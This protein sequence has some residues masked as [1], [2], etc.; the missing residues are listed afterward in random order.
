MY[1]YG[2][3]QFFQTRAQF[4]TTCHTCNFASKVLQ[5]ARQYNLRRHPN[6]CRETRQCRH[7][8]K[9][10][11]TLLQQHHENRSSALHRSAQEMQRC[12]QLAQVDCWDCTSRTR[13]HERQRDDSTI[14]PVQHRRWR[15]DGVC[16]LQSASSISAAVPVSVQ[17]SAAM[18]TNSL[19]RSHNKIAITKS[20]LRLQAQHLSHNEW[21]GSVATYLM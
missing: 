19:Q 6:K 10:F 9:T 14:G 7:P 16:R 2:L 8:N 1:D 21:R 5:L 4:T 3:T 15:N 13:R 17:C 18:N 20:R 12:V 11:G